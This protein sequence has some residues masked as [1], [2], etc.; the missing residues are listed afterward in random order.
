MQPLRIKP[1]VLAALCLAAVFAAPALAAKA[2]PDG[3]VAPVAEAEQTTAKTGKDTQEP[4]NP[5]HPSIPDPAAALKKAM[6][7]QGDISPHTVRAM[8]HD[9]KAMEAIGRAPAKGQ[10]GQGAASGSGGKTI[11]GDIII[12]R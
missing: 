8:Q 1:A 6:K 10:Q 9:P 4:R 12:H 7:A 11:Y 5:A 2:N 3:T